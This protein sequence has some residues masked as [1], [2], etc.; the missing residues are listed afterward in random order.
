MTLRNAFADLALD[1]T[2]QSVLTELQ[3]K[4]EP[5]QSVVVS[6]VGGTVTVTGTVALDAATLAA[7][8]T[9]NVNQ[10]GSWTVTVTDGGGSIT[11]DGPLT[12]AELRAAPV[13][14]SD[15][16]GSITVDGPLTDAELRTTPID[17]TDPAVAQVR[18]RLPTAPTATDEL[19]VADDY[20]A[21]EVLA[22]QTGAAAVLNFVFSA[23]VNLVVVH[24]VGTNQVARAT[25]TAQVPTATLG[26]RCPDDVPT[27]MPVT[28]NQIDVYAPSG[29]DVTVWGYRR[30]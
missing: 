27:Y 15:G 23:S 1:S 26:V 7:L 30:V 5:G 4:L 17:V 28:T 6:S 2:L 13:N 3:Q 16:G 14:I 20:G 29:M 22:D 8:E 11:V 19:P 9:V 12:D 18:D 25:T 10:A 24:A 21:L